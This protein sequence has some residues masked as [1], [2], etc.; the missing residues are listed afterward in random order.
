MTRQLNNILSVIFSL[1]KFLLIKLIH[2]KRFHFY[3]IQRF[4]PRTQIFFIGNGEI[5]LGKKVRAHTGVRI[6]AINNGV[7]DIGQN[8]SLNYGCMIVA[9]GS[10][11]ISQG[12]EFGPN[13]LVYDHDH[14]FRVTGGI[15]AGKY[16]ISNV[17]IGKNCWIGANSIILKGTKLGENCV[18]GAGTVVKG[19]FPSNSLIIN[20]Q[21]IEVSTTNL[22]AGPLS[23]EK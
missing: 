13:V 6:R 17:E 10:I 23:D 16:K 22:N 15:K 5:F 21:P 11:K 3:P 2:F 4:S 19:D 20:K 8:V 12:V 14:D 18:V 7:I 1:G 9:M